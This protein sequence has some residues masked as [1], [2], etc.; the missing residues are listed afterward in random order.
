MCSWP[1]VIGGHLGHCHTSQY[2][3]GKFMDC[4]LP[5]KTISVHCRSLNW[6]I[7]KFLAVQEKYFYV[8]F[9][10]YTPYKQTQTLETTHIH[11][12]SIQFWVVGIRENFQFPGMPLQR[13][14]FALKQVWA[15][16]GLRSCDLSDDAKFVMVGLRPQ[17][18]AG[19]SLMAAIERCG[20]GPTGCRGATLLSLHRKWA[21]KGN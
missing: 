7:E 6:C 10:I 4:W 17:A 20:A 3:K 2:I 13:G 8:F 1:G 12:M 14:A 9:Y 16:S 5:I 18:A 19:C 15:G 21:T 11:L